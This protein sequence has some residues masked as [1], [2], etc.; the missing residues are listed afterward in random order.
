MERHSAIASRSRDQT[1]RHTVA[2]GETIHKIASRYGVSVADLMVWNGMTSAKVRRG[3]TLLLAPPPADPTLAGIP[4]TPVPEQAAEASSQTENPAVEE[5]A[6]PVR[7]VVERHMVRRGES[8][9]RIA[10]MYGV[11]IAD[12]VAWNDLPTRQVKAG[13]K[14]IVSEPTTRRVRERVADA[15]REE[16]PAASRSVSTE[17]AGSHRIRRGE[18]LSSIAVRYGVSEKDLIAANGLDGSDI[19]A[20]QKLVIPAQAKEP[21]KVASSVR[22]ATSVAVR[23]PR[24]SVESS[25]DR[26]IRVTKYTVRPGDTLYSIARANSTT[27]DTLKQLN[28]MSKGDIRV[29]QVIK[30]PRNS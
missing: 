10:R 12:L 22:E 27:V 23:E 7:T 13:A 11:S 25:V 20:G 6:K 14:L 28:G 18:T 1:P 30:V 17:S 15:R 4:R 19:R 3:R 21:V 2:R 26:A 24:S 5:P 9:G 8:L 29:G 16:A